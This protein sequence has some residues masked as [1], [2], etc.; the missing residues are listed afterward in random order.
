MTVV[1]MRRLTGLLALGVVAQS[2]FSEP[3]VL[4]QPRH[5]V[6]REHALVPNSYSYEPILLNRSSSPSGVFNSAMM[7]I[8]EQ[9]DRNIDGE[10]RARPTVVSS[11]ADLNNL[12]ETTQLGRL[13]T[14]HLIHE[15]QLRNWQVTDFRLTS[16]FIINEGG[17]F[18]L[19]RNVDKL[20]KAF[21]V[22]NVVTGTYSRT[23]DGVIVNVRV[24]DVASGLVVSSAQTRFE[25]DKFIGSMVDKPSPLPTMAIVS[26]KPPAPPPPLVEAVKPPPP[27]SLG[28]AVEQKPIIAPKVKSKAKRKKPRDPVG[29]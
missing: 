18:T 17:E 6:R 28:I 2:V 11:I 20:K 23:P 9:L 13:V 29:S 21:S 27:V 15:L 22:A 7:F 24:I 14:E 19:S 4:E 25:K 26:D 12:G 8:A 5:E 1:S 16:D 3:V 10:A